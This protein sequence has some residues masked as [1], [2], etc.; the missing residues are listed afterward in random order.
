MDIAS[1]DDLIDLDNDYKVYVGDQLET[2]TV[3]S[4]DATDSTNKTFTIT[5]A[6]ALTASEFGKTITLRPTTD[7]DVADAK[8]NEHKAFT[9][10]TV[11]K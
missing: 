2:A 4:V 10:F 7:F 11:T 3:E 1:I 8:G 9:S 6:D 5:F